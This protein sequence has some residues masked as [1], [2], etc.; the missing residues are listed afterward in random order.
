M[1]PSGRT[2]SRRGLKMRIGLP[3]MEPVAVAIRVTV[4]EKS[5]LT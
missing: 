1:S 3:V 5:E 2:A 4:P